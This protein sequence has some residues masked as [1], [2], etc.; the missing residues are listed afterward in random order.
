VIDISEMMDDPDFVRAY[1]VSRSSGEF[2]EGG[3]VEAT[4]TTLTVYGPVIVSSPEDLQLI[5]EG[6]RVSGAMSFYSSERLYRTHKETDPQTSGTSDRITWN[7]E[8]YRIAGIS[9]YMDY[10]YY[11]AVAVRTKGS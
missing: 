11:K 9:P 1:T 3:W 4:P 7:G 6:D 2:A 10:G 8:E 5:P